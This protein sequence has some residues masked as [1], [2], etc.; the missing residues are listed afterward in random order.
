MRMWNVDPKVLCDKHLL[1]EHV[2]MHMFI[3]TI[4][5]GISMKGYVEGGLVEMTNIVKRHDALAL[6]MLTRG[7]RHKSPIEEI[8]Y[9]FGQ[10]A[11]NI[12]ANL[13]ELARRCP[14]CAAKQKE[15]S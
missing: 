2:E 3:G 5:K 6:E 12:E 4:K 10:G 13:V 9:P 1:G 11:V 15:L 14:A 8:H 7:M